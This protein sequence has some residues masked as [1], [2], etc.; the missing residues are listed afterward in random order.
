MK[1]RTFIGSAAAAAL[2]RPAVA[3]A[4]KTLI[5]VPQG[6]LVS[7]DPVWT[8]ATVTRNAAAMVFETLWGRDAA[9]N[10]QPQM[11]AG[12]LV[13][14]DGRRWT[15]TLREGLAF[16]DGERVLA[17][18]CVASVN[19]WMKRDPAGQTI[20]ERL[21]ALEAKDDR[22]LVFRLKKPF[23]GLP[24]ALS[25]TQPTPA[26]MPERLANTDPFKQIPEMIGS[27][28]FKYETREYVSGNRAVFSRNE[29]YLP[30]DEPADYSS[31]GLRAMV[32]RVE[33]RI[34]PDPAT[35]ANALVAGEIDWL[36][37]PLP[38]LLGMLRKSPGVTV[39]VLDRTGYY[40]VLR[41]NWEQ[42]PTA[43]LGVR[44]AMLAAVDQVEVMTATMGEDRSLYNA[45]VGLFVPGSAGE[46]EA[47][48]QLVRQRKSVADI[49]AMLAA[50]GYTGEKIV[51]FHPT[52]QVFYNAMMGVVAQAFRQI[53]LN[54]EEV[55]TDWGTV[56]ER[57]TSHA[58][59]DKGGWSIFPAGNPAAEYVDP[60]LPMAVR[61]NG[62][63]AW[64]GWPT[65][66]RLEALRDQWLDETDAAKQ[67]HLCEKIQ[68]R[69]LEL[70]TIIPLG[71]Y[72]PPAA[73]TKKISAPLPGLVP[74]FWNVT[75]NG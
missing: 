58:P 41:P 74:V 19:R 47:G 9:L 2:A 57:R 64:F 17:R 70:V 48:M 22:T 44:Q 50:S 53:G 13:E 72:L 21:D 51:L 40:G 34:I 42:G 7:I 66:A 3:Q 30:R 4:S 20:S 55:A 37:A 5:F 39:G 63:K 6:N 14:E 18:D 62:A 69:A 33:W 61:A 25:K 68:A 46:N 1:R 56:V 23:A 16:H 12:A 29:K 52:D 27:G 73:W 49:K 75:K 15:L 10:P 24:A 60:L 59:L 67:K 36:E 38:D 54:V 35:A 28:P 26:M 31:G 45:P 65:D 43:N 32:D 8:T 11:L 71:Q